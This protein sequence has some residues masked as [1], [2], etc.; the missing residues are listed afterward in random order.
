MDENI[1]RASC[2]LIRVIRRCFYTGFLAEENPGKKFYTEF[3][4]EENLEKRYDTGLFK[5]FTSDDSDE[6]VWHEQKKMNKVYDQ[7]RMGTREQSEAAAMPKETASL[8]RE[9]VELEEEQDK[10]TILI[11][12]EIDQVLNEKKHF[13]GKNKK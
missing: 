6:E 7:R 3:L 8:L 11:L 12:N 4:A 9:Q 2:N 5:D 10:D 1:N 13:L